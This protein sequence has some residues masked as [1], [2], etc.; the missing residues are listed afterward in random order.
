MLQ[1]ILIALYI[2]G[3]NSNVITTNHISLR[4]VFYS[5]IKGYG[6][7]HMSTDDF[8]LSRMTVPYFL[9]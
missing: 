5:G 2:I 6:N 3:Y 8:L 7:H 1:L 9:Q 4:D